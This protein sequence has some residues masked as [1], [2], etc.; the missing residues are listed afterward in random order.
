M[1][2]GI[3]QPSGIDADARRGDSPVKR[4]VYGYKLHLSSITIII[5]L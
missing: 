3:V 1:K 2:K 5:G 4:H